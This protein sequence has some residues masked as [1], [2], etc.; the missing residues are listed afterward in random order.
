MIL[1]NRQNERMNDIQRHRELLNMFPIFPPKRIH[2]RRMQ[3]SF[4]NT[5]ERSE[6]MSAKKVMF[7]LGEEELRV[8][9]APVEGGD[10][11]VGTGG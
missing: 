10:E 5:T 9:L 11:L 4:R 7:S 3:L 6:R 8:V 1:P 2:L